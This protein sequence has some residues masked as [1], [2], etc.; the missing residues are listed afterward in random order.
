MQIFSPLFLNFF[1]IDEETNLYGAAPNGEYMV[2]AAQLLPRALAQSSL[3]DA[4]VG[5]PGFA[6]YGRWSVRVEINDITFRVYEDIGGINDDAVRCVGV[7]AVE[8]E[9]K[10]SHIVACGEFFKLFV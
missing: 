4:R 7:L 9:V 1:L 3:E 5:C 8:N 10:V 2:L 6:N